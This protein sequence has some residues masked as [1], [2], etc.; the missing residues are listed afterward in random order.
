MAITTQSVTQIVAVIKQQLAEPVRAKSTS[1]S[2][3]API[4][5]AQSGTRLRKSKPKQNRLSALIEKRVGTLSPEDPD[6][7]GKAFRIFL[8]SVLINEF[9]E[10]MIND[11]GF[12]QM[13]DEVQLQMESNPDIAQAISEATAQLLIGAI[14]IEDSH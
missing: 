1:V 13:V 8:E 14:P 7:G 12:Y 9:G 6:R 3:Q 4:T 5:R 10:D 11:P 2:T